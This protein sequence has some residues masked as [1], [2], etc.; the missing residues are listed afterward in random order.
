MCTSFSISPSIRR[1]D[2]DARP[3]GDDLGDVLGVDH[4]LEEARLRPSSTAL[5]LG[6]RRRGEPLL[7]LG[8]RPVLELGGAAEVGLALGALEL[9]LGLLELLL[10]LGH[11]ADGLLLALPLGVHRVGALAL[12]GQRALELL[13]ARRGARRRRRRPATASSISSCMMCRSTS[14]ISVGLESISIR[15]RD[16]ASSTRSIALSGRKRSAM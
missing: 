4:V 11:G 2:R 13:A 7:E 5:V 3:L 9:D 6:L 1:R 10:E 15:I 8:D 16:A 12:L 14:S